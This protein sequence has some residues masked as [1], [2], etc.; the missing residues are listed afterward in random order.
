M[1]QSGSSAHAARNDRTASTLAKA[2]INCMPWSK[3]CCAFSLSEEI[4]N[5]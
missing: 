4:G 5:E 1:A 3:N 2:Y